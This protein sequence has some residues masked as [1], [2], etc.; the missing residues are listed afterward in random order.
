M[1]RAYKHVRHYTIT[2]SYYPHLGIMGVLNSFVKCCR[3]M[4]VFLPRSGYSVVEGGSRGC[5]DM[6][7]GFGEGG[8]LHPAVA[9]DVWTYSACGVGQVAVWTVFA[10]ACMTAFPTRM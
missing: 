8:R 3:R 7:V 9:Y 6:L 10:T 5:S 1:R 4:V 2:V